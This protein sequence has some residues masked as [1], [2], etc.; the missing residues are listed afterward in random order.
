MS[1]I[2]PVRLSQVGEGTETDFMVITTVD[3]SRSF[4]NFSKPRPLRGT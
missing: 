1:G 4:V 2:I 3:I